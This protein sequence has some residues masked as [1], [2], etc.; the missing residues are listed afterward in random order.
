MLV[1]RRIIFK[2]GQSQ[3]SQSPQYLAQPSHICQKT[4]PLNEKK[5]TSF[6]IAK[7]LMGKIPARIECL[8]RRSKHLFPSMLRGISSKQQFLSW[9]RNLKNSD[10]LK[11]ILNVRVFTAS[12]EWRSFLPRGRS[13]DT[14]A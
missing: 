14:F 11:Q 1:A 5:P 13:T 4:L 6:G 3:S 2:S 10:F 12:R 9:L 7:Y 8:L